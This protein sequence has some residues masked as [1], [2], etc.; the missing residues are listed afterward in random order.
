MTKKEK[1]EVIKKAFNYY[2]DRNSFVNDEEKEIENLVNELLEAINYTRSCCKLK[3]KETLTF[4]EWFKIKGYYIEDFEMYLKNK[5]K[6]VVHRVKK[7][8]KKYLQNL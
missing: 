1:Q 6:V 2:R 7:E 4:E 8:Y 5:G 3:D